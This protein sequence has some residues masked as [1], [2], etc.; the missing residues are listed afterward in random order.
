[1]SNGEVLISAKNLIKRFPIKGGVFGKEVAAVKAV[2][3]TKR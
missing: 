3:D 1:M 2:S